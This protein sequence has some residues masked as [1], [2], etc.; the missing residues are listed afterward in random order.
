MST[1]RF[2]KNKIYSNRGNSCTNEP[3]HS[4]QNTSY[5]IYEED[6]ILNDYFQNKNCY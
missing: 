6:E 5:K 2:Y 3:Q 4:N 1:F